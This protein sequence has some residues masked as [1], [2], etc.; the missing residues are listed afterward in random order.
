MHVVGFIII[1]TATCYN[2]M[3]KK[4]TCTLTKTFAVVSGI[5]H[6]SRS[7]RNISGSLRYY[8]A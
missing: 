1:I 8:E 6:V 7:Q 2:K 4:C 3:L 5:M